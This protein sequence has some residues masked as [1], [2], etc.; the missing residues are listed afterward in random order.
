PPRYTNAINVL[1]HALGYFSKLLT[2]AEKSH[3]LSS[4]ER[5]RSG[6]LPLSAPVG[7][8]QSW[9]VRFNEPYL[10]RQHFFRP[11]PEELLVISDSGKGRDR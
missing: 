4:L 8:L 2:P 5:Y 10:S 3:F 11:Y 7:I 6:R 9:I 1:M